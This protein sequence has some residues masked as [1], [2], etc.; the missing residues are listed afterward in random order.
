MQEQKRF[1]IPNQIDSS[2]HIWR[3]VR[4]KDL[5]ILTPPVAVSVVLFMYVLPDLPFQIRFFFS[6]L[7][8]LTTACL[9]FIRPMERKNI[10]LFDYIR[11][12]VEYDR[13]QRI[14]YFKKR[15]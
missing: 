7:P 6:V 9:I 2:I 13:R 11:Y 10:T 15:R 12:K 1:K 3:F 8:S 14:Y 4:L 5:I